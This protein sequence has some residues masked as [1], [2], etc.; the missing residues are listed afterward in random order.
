M[1]APCPDPGSNPGPLDCKSEV[2][3]SELCGPMS[4]TLFK[5]VYKLNDVSK[6]NK[7]VTQKKVNYIF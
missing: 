6:D 3:P 7:S 1:I 2:L 4:V 5:D